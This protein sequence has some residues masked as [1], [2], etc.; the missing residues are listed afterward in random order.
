MILYGDEDIVAVR[1]GIVIERASGSIYLMPVPHDT[2]QWIVC[3]AW[4]CHRY[5]PAQAHVAQILL[6]AVQF[7]TAHYAMAGQKQVS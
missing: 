4:P 2:K 7:R 6:R 1:G 5:H 3:S